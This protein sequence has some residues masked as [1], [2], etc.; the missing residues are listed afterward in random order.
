MVH[1]GMRCE[2]L[3]TGGLREA[4][5]VYTPDTELSVHDPNIFRWIAIE[6]H[7]T[8]ALLIFMMKVL[9]PVIVGKYLY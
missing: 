4:H 8:L 3:Y 1:A 7:R 9:T 6:R 2:R 5:R